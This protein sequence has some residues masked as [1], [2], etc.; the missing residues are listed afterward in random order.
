MKRQQSNIKR[1]Q[2]PGRN[3]HALTCC[4]EESSKLDLPVWTIRM[5]TLWMVLPTQIGPVTHGLSIMKTWSEGR[6]HKP[7]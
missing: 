1:I 3:K 2:L 5:T 7:T 4:S 6:A